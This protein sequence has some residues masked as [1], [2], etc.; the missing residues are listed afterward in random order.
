MLKEPAARLELTL[1]F[2]TDTARDQQDG[3]M[4]IAKSWTILP[5]VCAAFAGFARGDEMASATIDP[6]SLGGGVYQYDV[7]LNDVGTTPVGT[8]WFSW[9]PGENF[10]PVMPTNIDSPAGWSDVVTHG[11]ATDGYGIQWVASGPSDALNPGQSSSSYQ[12]QSTV[13]PEELA[14]ANMFYLSNQ[15]PVATSFIYGGAPRSDAGFELEPTISSAPEPST[16]LWT[17]VI[18]GAL[19]I[20][21]YRRWRTR[22]PGLAAHTSCSAQK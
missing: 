16:M 21:R 6:T 10:M 13:T 2:L 14:A 9:I 18:F 11:G 4:Q 5:I 8:F 1:L 7:T 15:L 19:L 22:N 3:H 12:F 20:L 17:G